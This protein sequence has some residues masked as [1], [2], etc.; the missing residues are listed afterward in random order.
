[1]PQVI[2]VLSQAPVGSPIIDSFSP[3]PVSAGQNT[4]AT[5]SN[6]TGVTS[7]TVDGVSASFVVNSDVSLQ[8]TIP[9]GATDGVNSVVATNT[10]GSGNGT[11][12]VVGGGGS[13]PTITSFT[14]TTTIQP[15]GVPGQ[16]ILV[17]GTNLTGAVDVIVGGIP[18][19]ITVLSDSEAQIIIPINVPFGPQLVTIT[20]LGGSGSLTL[21]ILPSTNANLSGPYPILI[22]Q[23]NLQDN[24]SFNNLAFTRTS[25]LPDKIEDNYAKYDGSYIMEQGQKALYLKKTYVTVDIV[26]DVLRLVAYI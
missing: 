24:Q 13:P 7:V 9:G 12:I 21:M 5:G 1:M 8:I 2:I 10:F 6:F 4:T 3:N 17:N 14:N 15:I 22:F 25:F 23:V 19:S 11:D 20:T 26:H 18:G 16:I